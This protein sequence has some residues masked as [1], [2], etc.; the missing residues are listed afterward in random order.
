MI[1]IDLDKPF[2]IETNAFDF[3]FGKQLVQRNEEKRLH[4]IT[5]FLKKL[6]KL[7]FN[8]FIH[9]KKLIIIIESFKEWKS[10]FNGT[11]YQIKVYIDYKN[12]IYFT[13]SKEF[14]QR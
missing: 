4:F 2:E 3:I 10:Y 5:F 13:T 1:I 11:R 12:L 9:N 6:Y 14:N 7:E 8:Y